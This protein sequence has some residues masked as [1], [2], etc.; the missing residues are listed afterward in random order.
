LWDV[1]TGK[2]IAQLGRGEDGQPLRL[3]TPAHGLAFAPDG[4]SLAVCQVDGTLQLWD[5][6][7]RQRRHTLAAHTNSGVS[8]VAFS[9]DG[10]LLASAGMDHAV[11]LWD[12]A[13]GTEKTTTPGAPVGEV[14][15][16]ALTPDGKT[17]VS[18]GEDRWIHVWDLAGGKEV[19][20]LPG[21]GWTPA[22]AL[23]A[24]GRVLAVPSNLNE[25]TLWDVTT[26]KELRVLK[27]KERPGDDRDRPIAPHVLA[28]A[29]SSDGRLLASGGASEGQGT[30]RLWAVE[31]GKEVREFGDAQHVVG[32]LAF[33]PDGQTL[34]STGSHADH[35]IRLW[36]TASGE[37]RRRFECPQESAA[38]V[39]WSPD[40]RTLAACGRW[41]RPI[42][43]WDIRTGSE[44]TP[45][46]ERDQAVC[47]LAFSP[48]GRWLAG[49]AG[50]DVVV[51]EWATG[52][53]CRRWP[54]HHAGVTSVAV[55]AA[56]RTLVSGSAD[57]T[58]LVW[59]A[60]GREGAPPVVA[61]DLDRLWTEL[62]DGKA[63]TAYRAVGALAAHP[64]LAV[65]L[66]RKRLQPAAVP[67]EREIDRLLADLDSDDFATRERATTALAKLG[68]PAESALR[69]LLAAHPSPEAR[70]RAERLL[71]RLEKPAL[72]PDQLRT[73]RALEVLESGDTPEAR[74]V[75]E[76]L[77]GGLPAAQLTREA[78]AAL[79]R[80]RRP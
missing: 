74:A 63:A 16:V 33:S 46:G 20:R 17:L 5:L 53:E 54:G 35:S 21:E 37:E 59:D 12:V 32:S 40:G 39:V 7:R 8:A 14:Q 66:L 36:A 49:A 52:Q 41:K 30:L 1:A 19:R 24:D 62:A 25:I 80:L 78:R 4:R 77:A 38:R 6:V 73:L 57:T 15:F 64:G 42:R 31:S 55:A 10:K 23:S 65:P 3:Y 68:E 18:R 76:A 79:E 58:V 9:S 44:L 29:F 75:L 67:A 47:C 13:A 28:L 50:H 11:R 71:E 69:E 22:A 70:L 45:L 27:E 34:A 72:S 43:R 61:S 51:W 56:G 48:S 2:E 60:T 26:G